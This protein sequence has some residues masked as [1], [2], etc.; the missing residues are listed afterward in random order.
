[1]L[2]LVGRNSSSE[3]SQWGFCRKFYSRQCHLLFSI[4]K[5][6]LSDNIIP[7]I[8]MNVERLLDDY[9]ADHVKSSSYNP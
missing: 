6:L 9:D 5:R 8:N 3:V 4:P 1:M 2:Y 7:F